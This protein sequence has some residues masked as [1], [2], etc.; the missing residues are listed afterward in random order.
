[1]GRTPPCLR[2]GGNPAQSLAVQPVS[3]PHPSSLRLV[4]I[5]AVEFQEQVN[6]A[7]GLVVQI[8]CGP[9]EVVL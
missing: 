3:F 2:L 9:P 6:L 4:A 1:M 8:R 5:A 7:L